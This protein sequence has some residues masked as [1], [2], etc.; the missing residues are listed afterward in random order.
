MNVVER[1]MNQV[2]KLLEQHKVDN[3]YLFGSV[4]TEK[5]YNSFKLNLMLKRAIERNIEIIGEATNRIL[6]R[7]PDIEIS[8]AV[9]LFCC[10]KI[11]FI[12]F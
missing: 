9:R 2:S 4:L 1:N 5:T 3:M 12:S 7:Q 6:A 11:Y 10:F 8:K